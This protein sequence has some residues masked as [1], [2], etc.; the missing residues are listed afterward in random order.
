MPTMNISIF[1]MQTRVTKVRKNAH[2]CVTER[3]TEEPYV[4]FSMGVVQGSVL[5]LFVTF[6]NEVE[7]ST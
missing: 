5:S 6:S 2:F 4:E 7:V 1:L 3:D